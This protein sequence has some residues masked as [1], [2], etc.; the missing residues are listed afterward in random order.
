MREVV[1]IG[2]R[3]DGPLYV[4]TPSVLADSEWSLTYLAP[5]GEMWYNAAASSPCPAVCVLLAPGGPNTSGVPYQ[6]VRTGLASQFQPV[7]LTG[8]PRMPGLAGSYGP[9]RLKARSIGWRGVVGFVR[10]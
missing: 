3:Q 7:E 2:E 10:F 8:A 4:R 6:S 5:R 9:A 1:L